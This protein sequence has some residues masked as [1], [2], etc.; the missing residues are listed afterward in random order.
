MAIIKRG[1]NMP[2]NK[3]YGPDGK[4]EVCSK[5]GQRLV[6]V[7]MSEND[8]ELICDNCDTDEDVDA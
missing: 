5:C 7:A 4:E 6:V 2:V 8:N 3:Y 1:D